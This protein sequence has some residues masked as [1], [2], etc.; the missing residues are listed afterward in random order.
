MVHLSAI[1]THF[2][3]VK[4]LSWMGRVWALPLRAVTVL[5]AA[6]L[7]GG[8]GVSISMFERFSYHRQVWGG[9]VQAVQEKEEV[10]AATTAREGR[11]KTRR[12]AAGGRRAGRVSCG[13]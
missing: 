1:F 12:T 10:A 8:I 13:P 3:V 6:S 4:Y 5:A 11:T 9:E 7:V 2:S